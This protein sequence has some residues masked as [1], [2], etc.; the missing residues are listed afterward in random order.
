M[1]K[2]ALIGEFIKKFKF[3]PTRKLGCIPHSL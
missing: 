3:W 1:L 2:V